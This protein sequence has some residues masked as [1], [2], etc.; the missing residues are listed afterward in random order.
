MFQVILSPLCIRTQSIMAKKK[1]DSTGELDPRTVAICAKIK[2][3]RID[4][5]HSNYENFAFENNLSRMQY[6][7]LEKGAN[8]TLETLYKVLDIHQITLTEFF[9]DIP[10]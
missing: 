7:R 4:A 10:G 2:K 5:G 6:F 3:L 9:E 1:Q 8:F